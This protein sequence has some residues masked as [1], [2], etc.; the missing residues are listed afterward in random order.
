MLDK[1]V[2]AAIFS[3][4]D[5]RSGYHQ[6]RIRPGDEWKTVFKTWDGLFEWRVLPFG[7]YNAP[8]TFMRLMNEIL[9]P[10]LGKYCVVYFD[11]ILVF[12]STL[13]AHLQHLTSIFEILRTH[14]LYINLPKCEFATGSVHFLGFVISS[15]GIHMD[16][17]KVSAI[18]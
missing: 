1:L 11:D 15:R 2:D 10:T 17:Q 18:T 4:L 7:L 9:R 16:A 13:Q 3:K 5:L 14:K 8:A 6:I 12:S